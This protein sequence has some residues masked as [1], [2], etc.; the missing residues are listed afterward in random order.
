MSNELP[1]TSGEA[2][3]SSELFERCIIRK[4]TPDGY[5]ITCRLGLWSVAGRW[6]PSV[7]QEA[8]H[9]WQQYFGDGEYEMH[10]SNAEIRRPGTVANEQTRSGQPGSPA[11]NG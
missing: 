10:L 9:Y 2:V 11:S 3:E 1:K 8:K 6:R 5:E 7:T 4:K